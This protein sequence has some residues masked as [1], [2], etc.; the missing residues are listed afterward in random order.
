MTMNSPASLT[1][2]YRLAT[3]P[4]VEKS[5]AVK[6]AELMREVG[7][8]C[9]GFNGVCP[10]HQNFQEITDLGRFLEQSI[11]SVHSELVYLQKS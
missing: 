6:T 11:V 1:E 2:L 10:S 3:S 4:S 7:L 8:K 9:I 5:E